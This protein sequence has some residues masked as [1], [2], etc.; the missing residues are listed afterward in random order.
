MSKVIDRVYVWAACLPI[1]PKVALIAAIN[2]AILVALY[3]I[4]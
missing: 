2:A 3:Q 1:V 4:S